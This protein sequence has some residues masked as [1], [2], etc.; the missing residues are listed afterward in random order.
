MERGGV[1]VLR[2]EVREKGDVGTSTQTAFD[3]AGD[4]LVARA[5]HGGKT[6]R[7]R[8][9]DDGHGGLAELLPVGGKDL[10]NVRVVA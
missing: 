1:V 5:G 10:E 3:K 4:G 2:A 8:K 9:F 7:G 6:R